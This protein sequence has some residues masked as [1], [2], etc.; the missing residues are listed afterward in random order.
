MMKLIK[1]LRFLFWPVTHLREHRHRKKPLRFLEIGPGPTRIAG[2][3]TLN[4][5]P[6]RDIDY[7]LDASKRLFF[8]SGSFDLIYANH[9]LE[10]IPWYQL[11][12]VLAEWVRI[13]K[14]DGWIEI[15]VPDG[16]KIC[17]AFID[18][19]IQGDNDID[20]DGWYCFNPERDPC[21][22]ASGRIFSY[23]DGTGRA[24]SPNWH[25]AVFSPRYL[26]QLLEGAGLRDVQLMDR[27]NIR[28]YD[29]GWINLGM[30]G[31]K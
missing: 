3:E 23:G 26:K 14:P 24:G 6:G 12:A 11:E 17:K 19:E 10:H 25:R 7:V 29:H 9:V 5:Q 18:A 13:L 8:P 4:I 27:S 15:W 28:S 20:Q 21:K 2:F 16:L 22:W 31:R 30:K 1:L